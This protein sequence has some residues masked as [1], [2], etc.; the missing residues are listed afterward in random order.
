[1]ENSTLKIKIVLFTNYN[2]INNHQFPN[3]QLLWRPLLSLFLGDDS[4]SV[5]DIAK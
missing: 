2:R 1:M 3:L 5:C 4:G